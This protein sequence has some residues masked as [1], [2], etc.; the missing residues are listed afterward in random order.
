M[1]DGKV[2]VPFGRFLGYD[3]GENGELVVNRKQAVIMKRIYSMFLK[4]MT[5]TAIARTLTAERIP[6]PG[7]K[8][9]WGS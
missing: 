4:G 9:K 6:T 1:A 8:E 2:S 5:Y 7:G 3:R